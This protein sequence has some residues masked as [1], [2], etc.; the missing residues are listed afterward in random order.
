MRYEG[1]AHHAHPDPLRCEHPRRV[2][3]THS[4]LAVSSTQCFIR[5][6]TNIYRDVGQRGLRLQ[7]AA[8][9]DLVPCIIDECD[10]LEPAGVER[11]ARDRLRCREVEL[12]G[13]LA[14][15]ASA[16]PHGVRTRGGKSCTNKSAR[17]WRLILRSPWRCLGRSSQKDL[18]RG[19]R[20][21]PGYR[22]CARSMNH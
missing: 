19:Q 14:L 9:D 16:V 7:R 3:D 22:F 11:I 21:G 1:V 5:V 18:L 20:A 17:A 12:L 13:R 10:R 15:D 2:R 4:A 8:R 6:T